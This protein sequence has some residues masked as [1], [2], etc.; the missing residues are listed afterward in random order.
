MLQSSI[1]RLFECGA[2]VG[3]CT[4]Y[5][6]GVFLERPHSRFRSFQFATRQCAFHQ[7]PFQRTE[8]GL[9]ALP[10]DAER[11]LIGNRK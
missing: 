2:F 4:D 6:G 1:S 11:I 5:D 10:V 9:K 7:R 8:R 3:V